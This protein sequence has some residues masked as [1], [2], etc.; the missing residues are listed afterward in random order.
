MASH[1]VELSIFFAGTAGSVPTQRRGLP[2]ILVRRGADRI[3]FDCGEGT[4]RQLV[5]SVGLAD[6][7]EVFLTHFHTDHWLG[8][9]GMLNTFNLRGRERPLTV[10]G[11]PGTQRLMELVA[12][13]S[14]RPGF[15][16]TVVE[17]RQGEILERDGYRIAP[18][19][20]DHRGTALGYV[21]WEDERPG[22]FDPAAAQ[23]AGLTPGPE[24]GQVQRGETVRGVAPADVM[25]A[26][27]P[28]RKLV[29][30]GDTRPSESLRVAA[31]AADV[32][33]HEA[34]FADA[35]AQ[36]AAANGHSTA[37]QAAELAREADVRLLALN[38]VSTRHPLG[39]LRDEAR[40]VF[41]G[42]VL[43][44]D[45][46]TIEIPYA[47]RGAP[48]LVRWS[49]LLARSDIPPHESLTSD[50]PASERI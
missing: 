9:P 10:H 42:T 39:L 45:F 23:A 40:A 11:P 46:D 26:A 15:A 22:V 48:H 30:S 3:L 19:E 2:A 18:V 16:L 47:E 49:E 12:R 35:E 5:S 28:G 38:H 41:P 20:V 14:G 31:T 43:P 1:G 32:L 6:L 27:R 8:L 36:R 25:G 13:M 50:T 4:Q 24:F 17:L 33:V 44:R 29:L 7:S 21:V 37:R 34:T